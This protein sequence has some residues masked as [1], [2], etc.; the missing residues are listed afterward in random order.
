MPSKQP[1]YFLG[2]CIITTQNPVSIKWQSQRRILFFSGIN[3]TYCLHGVPSI[4][5]LYTT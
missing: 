5:T 4:Y 1:V 3:N 2:K